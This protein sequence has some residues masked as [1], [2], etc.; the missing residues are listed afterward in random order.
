LEE[1]RRIEVVYVLN[2]ANKKTRQKSS[3]TIR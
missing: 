2:F 1:E 3:H